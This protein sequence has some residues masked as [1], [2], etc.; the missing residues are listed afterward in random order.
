[1][2]TSRSGP[3]SSWIQAIRLSIFRWY[4]GEGKS[5]SYPFVQRV[6]ERRAQIDRKLYC[7][8][9]TNAVNAT[10]GTIKPLIIRTIRVKKL[11]RRELV[12]L[13]T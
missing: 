12:K 7:K 11:L 13:E 4:C 2:T 9:I 1:M 6:M 5:G 10:N 3:G 8:P